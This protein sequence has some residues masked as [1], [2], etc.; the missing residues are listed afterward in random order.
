MRKLQRSAATTETAALFPL[1][2]TPFEYY[3]F[4]DSRLGNSMAFVIELDVEGHVV[5]EALEE[6]VAF[7]C[8]R[9]PLCRAV[10]TN[11]RWGCK[12]WSLKLNRLPAIYWSD[13]VDFAE[14]W[15]TSPDLTQEPGVRVYVRD[16]GDSATITFQF[17]H[18]CCD[19]IGAAVWIQDVLA[20]YAQAT[21][22][23]PVLGLTDTQPVRLMDRRRHRLDRIRGCQWLIKGVRESYRFFCQLPHALAARETCPPAASFAGMLTHRFDHEETQ[24]LRHRAN[25]NQATLNDWLLCQLFT[26]IAHWNASTGRPRRRNPWYRINMPTSLRERAD[27]A[28][29]AA[30]LMSMTF[31]NRRSKAILGATNQ[32]LVSTRQESEEIKRSRSGTIFLDHLAMID[33][34]PGLLRLIL[35]LPL[36]LATVVLTNMGDPS[37]R[38][39]G[40]LPRQEGKLI[41][42][43]LVVQRMAGVPPLRRHTHAAIGVNT[44]AEQ[45]TISVQMTPSLYGQT[46]MQRFLDM[47]VD[48]IRSSLS[49]SQR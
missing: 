5:R 23:P 44:Y 10:V 18:A 8:D 47:Y 38:T 30:N 16:D 46:E 39:T 24:Q 31:F 11:G 32:L 37:R 45:L 12:Y 19:G 13:H 7:A 35:S 4:L 22:G 49:E 48:R 28:T 40:H 1:R 21:G 25:S 26:T 34:V 29:P 15:N 36:S 27:M 41:A 42:G 2:L 9:H 33:L 20:W 43:N 14:M 17:H 3:M 6:A